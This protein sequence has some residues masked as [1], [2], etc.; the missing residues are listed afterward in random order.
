MFLNSI[1]VPLTLVIGV[2]QTKSFLPDRIK[3]HDHKITFWLEIEASE[4][5]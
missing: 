5:Y 3:L 1:D 4:A 2:H